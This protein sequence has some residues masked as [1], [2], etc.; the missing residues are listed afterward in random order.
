MWLLMLLAGPSTYLLRAGGLVLARTR[1]VP[2]P[3]ERLFPLLPP[4]VLAAL[5]VPALAAAPQGVLA[6]APDT[7]PR[8]LVA[9]LLLPVL[10]LLRRTPALLLVALALGMGLLWGVGW[11]QGGGVRLD[12]S[13]PVGVGV[14]DGLLLL[15]VA[16]LSLRRAQSR[17]HFSVTASAGTGA[18]TLVPP[19]V[20]AAPSVA[21]HARWES[22]PPNHHLHCPGCWCPLPAWAHYCGAC[23][24][25]L[26][27]PD[28]AVLASSAILDAERLVNAERARGMPVLPT[29][30]PAAGAT[31]LVVIKRRRV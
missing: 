10:V 30:S 7:N 17:R 19:A 1:F 16:G 29:L 20:A 26:S 11:L 23:G 12:A 15:S 31:R 8:L 21:G 9:L 5:V 4:A 6:L 22:S 13:V 3:L 24:R 2:R 18:P 25:P 27:E 14:G 28:T